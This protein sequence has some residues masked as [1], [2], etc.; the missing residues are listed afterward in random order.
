MT[1]QSSVRNRLRLSARPPL[2]AFATAAPA[3][4]FVGFILLLYGG[5]GGKTSGVD[6]GGVEPPCEGLSLHD[7]RMRED[8]AADT[9]FACSC[10]PSF[11]QCRVVS[12][13]AFDCP[14][15]GCAQP[16]CCDAADDCQ[17]MGGDCAPPGTA[18]ACGMCNPDP[19]DC[20]TDDECATG[21][22]CA[23]MLC[24]CNGDSQCVAGCTGPSDCEV[25]TVCAGGDHPRCETASCAAA[26]PCPADFDC[27]T[28]ECARRSCTSDLECDGYCVEGSCYAAMGECVLPVP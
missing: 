4:A 6:D 27:A 18:R 11:E 13:P 26:D 1:T 3:A 28:S 23:P 21:D 10:W 24:A 12:D 5:C 25:G 15:L 16:P 17:A 2:E 7:C 22:I 20:T 14:Q 19:G 8:C 9:C